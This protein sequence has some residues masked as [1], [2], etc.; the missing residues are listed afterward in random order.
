MVP[1]QVYHQ[2]IKKGVSGEVLT[3]FTIN[4][5][6]LVTDIKVLRGSRVLLIKEAVRI[7][8]L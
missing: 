4:E 7:L 8:R 1:L 6:G 5:K 2:R 3:T